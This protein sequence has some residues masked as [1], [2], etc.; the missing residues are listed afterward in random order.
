[1]ADSKDGRVRANIKSG[2]EVNI[3]VTTYMSK[4]STQSG[5]EFLTS[6]TKI[7]T[8]ETIRSI[9]KISKYFL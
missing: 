5:T 4:K 7:A 8:E 3:V 6:Y 9:I 1:M 2:K